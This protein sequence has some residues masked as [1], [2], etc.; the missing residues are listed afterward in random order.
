IDGMHLDDYFY[1][2]PSSTLNLSDSFDDAEYEKNTKGFTDRKEWRRDNVDKMIQNLSVS[3]HKIKPKLS[4]GVSPFGIWRNVS[5]DPS[6]SNTKGLQA[7][8]SLYADSVK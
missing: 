2:Y 3:V 7:Y 1:P 4:F 6:G 5:S 8:D